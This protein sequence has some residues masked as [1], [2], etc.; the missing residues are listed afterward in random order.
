MLADVR[1]L[2]E[3]DGLGDV[4]VLATSARTG[5]GI[6]ELRRAIGKRVADKAAT[7]TR[8]AG[9][10]ADAAARL[11]AQNGDAEP[12]DLGRKDRR[13][14]VDALADA[15]GRADRRRRRPAGH[16]PARAAR[17]R[18]AA[19]RLGLPA[20]AGPAAPAAPRPGD[21]RAGTSIAG[22][23]GPRCRR[24]TTCSRRAS[25]RPSA[26]C[27]TTSSKGLAQP[28]VRSVRQASTSRFA[29]LEDRLDRAVATT[30]LG[31]SGTPVWCRAVRVLQWVLLVAALVGGACGWRCWPACPTCRCPTPEHAGLPR[32]SRC[33]R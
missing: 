27:A 11:A 29:D 32:A 30:D 7:R 23:A 14:L 20:A 18:L 28:W 3:A 16:H 6:D 19:D 8:L 5:E 1:R 12:R 22:R 4:P 33:R 24:P 9:D 21:E 2:L 15:A 26:P 25:R 17:H 10:I 31:V 13:E